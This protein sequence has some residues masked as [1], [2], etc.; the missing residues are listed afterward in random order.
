[1]SW[2][3]ARRQP[4]LDVALTTMLMRFGPVDETPFAPPVGEV[5][6]FVQACDL[7]DHHRRGS[8]PVGRFSGTVP[9]AVNASRSH[10]PSVNLYSRVVPRGAVTRALA[11]A[12]SRHSERVGAP[13]S[14]LGKTARQVDGAGTLG[15]GARMVAVY[16][17][18]ASAGA[19]VSSVS[20]TDREQCGESESWG[21]EILLEKV[22]GVGLALVGKAS[23]S[24]PHLSSN[25]A[26]FS[27]PPPV[28][29]ARADIVNL[30]IQSE[31][32][33]GSVVSHGHAARDHRRIPRHSTAGGE[34]GFA[35]RSDRHVDD[36][37]SMERMWASLQL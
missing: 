32:E 23:E 11:G 34:M 29:S 6:Y 25:V 3:C 20:R 13:G 36:W 27:A 17:T 12:L 9:D 1:M 16:R 18:A 8:R 35:R 22:K 7:L 5:L 33:N 31:E 24:S 21:E 14:E 26:R 37:D 28:L 19:P 10:E 4:D 2:D 30:L 15:T